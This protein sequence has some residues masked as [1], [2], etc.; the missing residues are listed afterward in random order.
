[1][2]PRQNG[3]DMDVGPRPVAVDWD[4]QR[5]GRCR[6]F[7]YDVFFSEDEPRDLRRRRESQAKAICSDCPVVFE[8][9]EH[10]IRTPEKYGVWGALSA[11]DRDHI[12]RGPSTVRRATLST[13]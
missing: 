9:R 8:C 11:S 12:V 5:H 7:S 2:T 1:M 4:W 13:G 10:A 6:G 3:A